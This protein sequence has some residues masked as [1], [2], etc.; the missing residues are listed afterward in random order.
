MLIVAPGSVATPIWDKAGPDVDRWAENVVY[1]APIQKFAE[2][3]IRDGRAGYTPEQLGEAIWKAL[4]AP[5]PAVRSAP[6]PESLFGRVVLTLMPQR[7]LDG[8]M[9]R[10]LG[11]RSL[12]LKRV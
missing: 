4:S 9:A 8:V 5:R 11:L 3:M 10:S 2:T 7:M 1:A 6:G 12:G